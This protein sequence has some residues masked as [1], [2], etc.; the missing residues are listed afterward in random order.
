MKILTANRL[1]DGECLWWGNGA[2]N[3]TIEGADIAADKEAEVARLVALGATE[4][5]RNS[6]GPD[7]DWVTLADPEGNAFC[8][9]GG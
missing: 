2:W 1:T 3:E 7:M 9:A 6:F 5:G 4:T 8:V